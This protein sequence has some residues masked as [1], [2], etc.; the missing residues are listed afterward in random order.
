[1][2]LR[3]YVYIWF[4]PDGTPCYVGK[5]Q[6]DRAFNFKRRNN[7]KLS[8]LIA[9]AGGQLCWAIIETGLSEQQALDRERCTI[10]QIGRECDG[11]GPLLN[12]TAGGQGVSGLKHSPEV[13]AEQSA[14]LRA[15]YANPENRKATSERTKAAMARPEVRAATSAAQKKRFKNPK[16]L[17]RMSFQ[18]KGNKHSEEHR[19]NI[20]AGLLGGKRTLASRA[21]MSAWQIGRKM[22]DEAKAKMS[23]AAKR[24]LSKPEERA[25]IAAIGKLGAAAR[26]CAQPQKNGRLKFLTP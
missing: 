9:A 24:R 17:E 1:M 23:A 20:A 18:R 15:F 14:R 26:W 5:G 4:S 22:S 11:T 3:F 25:R 2:T 16:E 19:A 10:A 12:I 8:A 7:R 13:K 6:G 21:K